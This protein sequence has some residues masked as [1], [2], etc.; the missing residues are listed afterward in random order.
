MKLIGL[1]KTFQRVQTLH[2]ILMV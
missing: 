1:L 2:M